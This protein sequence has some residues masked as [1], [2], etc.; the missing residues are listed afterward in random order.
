MPQQDA[1]LLPGLVLCGRCG[2]RMT[3]RY[4]GTGGR[5]AVC[6]CARRHLH[7]GQGGMCWTVP[8]GPLDASVEAHGLAALTQDNLELALAVLTHMEE[9]AHGLDRHWHVQLERARYAVQRAERQYDAVEPEHR[10]VART[11][12]RH[13][14]EQLQH[15]HEVERAYA[16]ARQTQRLAVSPEART[17]IL[18]LAAHLPAVWS[19][20]TTTQAERK[21]LLGLLVKQVALTPVD[22]AP[23]QTQGQGLWHTDVVTTLTVP[24]PSRRERTRTPSDVVST[25]A[26]LA[27]THT[28]AAIAAL[29]NTRGLRS[30]KGRSFTPAAV[31][32]VRR[33]YGIAKPLM[34][35]RHAARLEA[36]PDGRCSTRA[37]AIQMG[38]SLHTI[39][40]WRKR[41][42]IPAIQ[43]TPGGP[44]WHD[45]TPAVLE[46]LQKQMRQVPIN[47]AAQ[48]PESFEEK[49]AL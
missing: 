24:R 22:T 19:A 21:R 38:V 36:R 31:V 46:S 1:A 42:M 4:S 11:L 39:H 28:D 5:H 17:Q 25:V 49:S 10:L 30:G 14:N 16:E 48:E 13:W 45:V 29:R 18:Q 2:R 34:D 23:R 7:D 33:K 44:W 26:T 35:T 3:V 32:W 47:T 8:A 15:L 6:Q 40:D 20:A 9:D 37:L 27:A 43:E 12:E 41:G